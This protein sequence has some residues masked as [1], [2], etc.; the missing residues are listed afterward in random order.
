MKRNLT[1]L[2]I[3]F[4]AILSVSA[5]TRR[6]CDIDRAKEICDERALDNVEGI[7]IYPD[8]Q[9]TVLVLKDE[10]VG[11][12]SILPSYSITVVETSDARLH[13]G[14][15][16][17]S[18]KSSAD[19]K[20]FAIELLTEK[21]N[22]LLLQPKTCTATLGNNGDTFIFKK[23][24]TGIRGRLNVNL[25]RLLPGFWKIVSI[26]LSGNSE[27]GNVAPPVGMVKIYPSYDGNGSSQRSI[28]Y[29]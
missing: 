4:V 13:P 20:V 22:N 6:I 7:W 16:I 25:N 1:F 5:E 12:R 19:S 11:G 14:D 9:V 26:G 29:L 15:K 3:T 24:K 18:L 28:R 2:L 21:K 8:D 17:G 23:G 27:N 10:T